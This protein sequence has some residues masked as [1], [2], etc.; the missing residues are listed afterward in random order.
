MDFFAH[1]IK[2]Y[3]NLYTWLNCNFDS[4]IFDLQIELVPLLKILF[5]W[6]SHS[7]FWTRKWMM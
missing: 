5:F 6:S 7:G 3:L 1:L 2:Q 4:S